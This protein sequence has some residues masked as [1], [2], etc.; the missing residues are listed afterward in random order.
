M[1]SDDFVDALMAERQARWAARNGF[2]ETTADG[3]LRAILERYDLPAGPAD[4]SEAERAFFVPELEEVRP[5][6]GAAAAL[7]RLNRG[8]LRTA[9]VS[10]ASSHHF[11]V[12]CCRRLLF[13]EFL[14]PIVSSAAVGWVK[15]DPRVFRA[16]L[17]PWNLPPHA[18]VMVGD[19]LAAD[20]AGAAALGM[21]SILLT[22]A[23]EP[24][25]PVALESVAADAVAATL[26]EAASIIEGWKEALT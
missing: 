24:G 26:A 22:A 13:A 20:I 16:V 15:P 23:H 7:A 18:V 14:D 19:S 1:V 25:A 11:V 5:L 6:A 12:E 17:R 10:N 9:L 21:R 3:A 8:G 4:V 2:E